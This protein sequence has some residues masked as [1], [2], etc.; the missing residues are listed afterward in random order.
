MIDGNRAVRALGDVAPDDGGREGQPDPAGGGVPFAEGAEPLKHAR[1]DELLIREGTGGDEGIERRR[2][3]EAGQ[4][5]PCH[6]PRAGSGTHQGP[7]ARSSSVAALTLAKRA[8]LVAK[9]FAGVRHGRARLLQRLRGRGR[10]G[11]I[12]FPGG[13]FITRPVEPAIDCGQPVGHERLARVGILEGDSDRQ[14]VGKAAGGN[15][16]LDL[17][18]PRL[19]RVER[20]RVRPV[21]PPSLAKRRRVNGK[22]KRKQQASLHRALS[23][24]RTSGLRGKVIARRQVVHVL[25]NQAAARFAIGARDADASSGRFR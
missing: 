14:S 5:Q 18:R 11:D 3:A 2:P 25:T 15:R 4:N 21:G 23:A 16:P 7:P 6:G 1:P 13:H 9:P 22:Q 8:R 12:A 20:A 19:K 17:A 24:H 10:E